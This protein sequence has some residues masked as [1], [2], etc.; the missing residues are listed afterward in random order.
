MHA[1]A[2]SFRM[3]DFVVVG[4]GPAGSRFARS[5]SERGRDVLVLESGEI[6]RSRAHDDEI[7]HARREGR[8]YG[9]I[10]R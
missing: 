5:A 7:V 6:G 4:A 2:P 8:E 9:N 1:P 10:L 3:Y